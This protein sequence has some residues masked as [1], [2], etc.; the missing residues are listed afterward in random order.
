MPTFAFEC[1]NCKQVEVP[2]DDFMKVLPKSSVD[3]VVVAIESGAGFIL[4]KFGQECPIC[5]PKL[6]VYKGTLRAFR[7][8]Q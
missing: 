8:V 2:E 4:L 5:N 7:R 6:T 1:D 3:L